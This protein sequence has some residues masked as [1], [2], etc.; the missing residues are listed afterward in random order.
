MS[1]IPP[2]GGRGR[3]NS[4]PRPCRGVFPLLLFGEWGS[5]L[6][7]Q[8]RPPRQSAIREPIAMSDFITLQAQ[9]QARLDTIRG[10]CR[11][12]FRRLDP[13]AR[14][15]AE[16]NTLGLAWKYFLQLAKHG[17]HED[18]AVFNAMVY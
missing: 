9:F 10:I 12:Q 15:E 14:D 4:C 8:H 16:A 11:F 5:V 17:K 6:Q 7:L 13:A 3:C 2:E 1:D 18:D